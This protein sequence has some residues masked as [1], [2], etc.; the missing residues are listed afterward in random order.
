MSILLKS[1][2][3]L[4]SKFLAIG[5]STNHD[6]NFLNNLA[7]AG[8]TLGNFIYIDQTKNGWQDKVKE[9]LSESLE[10]A[11]SDSSNFKF[12]LE[13]NSIAF[14]KVL[15]TEFNYIYDETGNTDEN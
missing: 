5:F 10:I 1:Y 12:Q 9:A 3:G 14:S 8:S 4:N 6:A 11:L 7:K 13:N 15:T 2:P